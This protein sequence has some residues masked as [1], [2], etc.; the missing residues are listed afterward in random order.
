MD[1]A[2]E[3]VKSRPGI[4]FNVR[5]LAKKFEC[6]A[7]ALKWYAYTDPAIKMPDPLSCGTHKAKVNCI[8][9]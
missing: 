3:Y 6:K 5:K 2:V 1:A 9:A 7:N 8:C 4:A